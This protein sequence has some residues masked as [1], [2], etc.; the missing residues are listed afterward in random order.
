MPEYKELYARKKE[1]SGQ[2]STLIRGLALGFIVVA[3]TLL[4][5]H[6]NPLM[7]VVAKVNKYALLALVAVSVLVIACDLLQ[8][9][10]IT[11]MAEEA[12]RRAEM[13]KPKQAQYDST[14]FAYRAQAALYYSKFW[15]LAVGATLLGYIF[16][17]I[18]R[19][20]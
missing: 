5:A 15:T 2:V 20:L 10:A 12:L 7:A 11:S 1:A 9:V 16:V 18:F 8:Y 3:W 19:S 17:V 13:V 6:D 4:T 14:T